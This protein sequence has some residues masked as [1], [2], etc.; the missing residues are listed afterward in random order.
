MPRIHCHGVSFR[1]SEAQLAGDVAGEGA[2][3]EAASTT[4]CE[5]TELVGLFSALEGG[6]GL[7][8]FIEVLAFTC[9]FCS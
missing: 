6:L 7:F 1:A 5:Q 8:E 3:A 2:T 9:V 4:D